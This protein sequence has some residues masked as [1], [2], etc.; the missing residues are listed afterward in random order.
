MEKV[1]V[2]FDIWYLDVKSFKFLEKEKQFQ[3]G[4][5]VVR[6]S[7]NVLEKATKGNKWCQNLVTTY[8]I[9][10][11]SQTFFPRKVDK[12]LQQVVNC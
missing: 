10:K 8:E 5:W 12:L 6:G 9:V 4:G 7:Y 3:K 2:D 11:T 1:T